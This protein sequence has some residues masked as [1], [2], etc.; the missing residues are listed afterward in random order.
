MKEED[1]FDME[2]FKAKAL[3][4]LHK[5]RPMMGEDGVLAP[6]MKHLLESC[7]EGEMDAHLS[8]EKAFGKANRKNG[9]SKKQVR[10]LDSGS[11][12]LETPRDRNGS[13]V[14]KAVG[15][16]QVIITEGLEEKVISLYAMGGSYRDISSH[17]Q[18][19]YAMD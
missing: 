13:F 14:P 11:F 17:I 1:S 19:L 5:G 6:L 2:A 4:G 18:E 16:R 15:K 7:L 12:E 9:K 3:E 8:K 10:S